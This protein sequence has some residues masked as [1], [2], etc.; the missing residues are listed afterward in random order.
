[1][2]IAGPLTS[3]H[4]PVDTNRI[5]CLGGKQPAYHLL[6]SLG[7]MVFL[8]FLLSVIYSVNVR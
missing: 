7:S 2:P 1:M 8:S 6:F 5:H 3:I 4:L